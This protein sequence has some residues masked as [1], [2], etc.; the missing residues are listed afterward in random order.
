MIK[1]EDFYDRLRRQHGW[2]LDRLD[3][4]QLVLVGNGRGLTRTIALAAASCG[5]KNLV[6]YGASENRGFLKK[7]AEEVTQHLGPAVLTFI[8]VYAGLFLRAR[9]K[10][11]RIWILDA[12]DM[13]ND[14][15]FTSTD[16]AF[17]YA[18]CYERGEHFIAVGIDREAVAYRR[19]GNALSDRAEIPMAGSQLLIGALQA[20][21][22]SDQ[23]EPLPTYCRIPLSRMPA[24]I[25]PDQDRS[26]SA[27]YAGGGGAISH[28]VLWTESL[29]PVLNHFN[30]RPQHHFLIVDPGNVHESCR[31]RQWGYPLDS[32]GES[33][34]A[35]TAKWI[36]TALFPHAHVGH[37]RGRLSREHFHHY[38]LNEALSSI[39]N[40]SG[41]KVLAK[42]AEAY[43]VPWWSAGSSFYGGFARQVSQKNPWCASADEGV[44]RLRDR[45]EDSTS[46][47]T[48]CSSPETPLPSSVLPQ[49]IVASF[50]A[51]QKRQLLTGGADQR[52]LAQGI[53]VHMTH[54]S[55]AA[56]YEGL[57]WSPGRSLNLKAPV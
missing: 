38:R 33:K 50:I 1:N 29:D 9:Q 48:S 41:R 25:D 32:C 8:P 44:E 28:Q 43:S 39:D 47:G 27:L 3:A 40:W 42:F 36:K 6:L 46:Q 34:A 37:I 45:P 2:K 13:R 55:M 57:R 53:E 49:M 20:M 11:Q 54:G 18:E 23:L 12:G 21:E 31:S 26:S 17:Y 51:V 24:G 30:N 35:N 15:V 22:A 14:N 5:V 7:V 4:Y 10:E 52:V 16:P 56:G 19:K